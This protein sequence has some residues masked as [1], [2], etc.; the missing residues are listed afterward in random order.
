M[1]EYTELIPDDTTPLA[2]ELAAYDFIKEEIPEWEPSDG[3][4][5]VWIIKTFS[6]VISQLF[7][8]VTDVS[9]EIFAWFGETMMGILRGEATFAQGDSIW[10]MVDAAGYTIPAGR[11]VR[12][13][14]GDE[15]VTFLTAIEVTV[16]PGDTVA[17]V[18]LVAAE[19]GTAANDLTESPALVDAL[20]FVEQIAMSGATAGGSDEETMD[21]Y[22]PRLRELLQLMS[23]RP[24][25]PEHFEVLA[26]QEVGVFRAVA[27][28]G[29]D[30]V[31]NT[32]GN[33]L[34]MTVAVMDE[35]GNPLPAGTSG[36]PGTR[37]YVRAGL[38][39]NVPIN[40]VVHVIDPEYTPIDV[41]AEIASLPDYDHQTVLN[42]VEEQLAN[43]FSP[44]NWGRR[45]GWGMVPTRWVNTEVVRLY[46]IVEVINRVVGVDYIVNL[47]IGKDGGAKDTTDLTLDGYVPLTRLG[48]LDLS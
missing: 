35:E 29:L 8:V 18:P 3:D 25:V 47:N 31:A 40:S 19:P 36:V 28:G 26:R 13:M 33:P 20:N 32:G 24:I 9:D 34:T 21:A 16:P 22:K 23:P 30:P 4:P 37:A 48:E 17:T 41:E 42:A 39:R 27:I 1:P 5:T 10:T 46:E 45:E 38:E 11:T 12:F 43:Y 7:E 44:I 6:G 2:I 15:S 14:D